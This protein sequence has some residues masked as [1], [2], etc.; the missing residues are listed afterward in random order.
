MKCKILIAAIA[1]TL[2]FAGTAYADEGRTDERTEESQ[3]GEEEVNVN[4]TEAE[5][6]VIAPAPN[7]A[8]AGDAAGEIREREDPEPSRDAPIEEDATIGVDT[9]ENKD[10]DAPYVGEDN[11]G[12]TPKDAP[13]REGEESDE[14]PEDDTT[15]GVDEKTGE[16]LISPLIAPGDQD[17]DTLPGEPNATAVPIAV[18]IG[19]SALILGAAFKR[20]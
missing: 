12:E 7:E 1:L 17:Q 14:P 8:K 18:T 10:G 16:P 15:I 20:H 11:D 19:C 3:P 9:D 5:A 4:V 6:V 2:L 13:A